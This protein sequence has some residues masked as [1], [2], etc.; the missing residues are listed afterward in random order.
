MIMILE[1]ENNFCDC[2]IRLFIF[3]G[4][5]MNILK[6]SVPA[7]LILLGSIDLVKAMV[8]ND[9]EKK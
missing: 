5:I 1:I 8:E 7:I 9:E 3:L 4:Y 6:I 2:L